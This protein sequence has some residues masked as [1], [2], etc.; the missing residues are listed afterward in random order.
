MKLRR[1]N[2]VE[3]LYATSL[4]YRIKSIYG[5]ARQAT[6]R[7]GITPSHPYTLTLNLL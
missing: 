2:D 4:Q 7:N 3:T 1:I 5:Y 6:S